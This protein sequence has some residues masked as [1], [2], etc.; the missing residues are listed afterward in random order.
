MGSLKEFTLGEFIDAVER[1][2]LKQAI[3]TY[4]ANDKGPLSNNPRSA[5]GAACAVGQGA[6]NL[7]VSPDDWEYPDENHD[8]NYYGWDATKVQDVRAYIYDL[9]DSE[10]MPIPEIAQR[11]R[12]TYPN[13]LDIK[14]KAPVKNYKIAEGATND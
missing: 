8:R 10:K 12:E 13:H 14:I 6:I 1:D 9:N 2:G 7:G 3:G 5:I 4:F 11:V